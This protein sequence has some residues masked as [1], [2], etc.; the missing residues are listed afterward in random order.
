MENLQFRK[1]QD[2]QLEQRMLEIESYTQARAQQRQQNSQFRVD[3]AI[4]TI[5]VVVHVIYNNANQNISD[6]QIQSQIDVI[7]EDFRR[8]NGDADNTWSQAADTQIEFCMAT[9]DPNGNAT[10][11]ITRKSSTR[12][13]WGTNDAMKSTSQGGVNPWPT[14]EYL[15][16]W[17]CNI[18]GGILGYAQFPGG[19]ASTDG[20]VMSPQYFGS[21]DKGSGFFLS[22]PFDK[23]RTTTHEIGHFLNL[24]H[25][26]GD[27]GCGVDDFV[28]DT[29]ESDASNGGCAT[30][31][32]SCGS[33]DMVQNYMD[34]SDDS[35]M[36]LFT[37]GQKNRMRDVLEAGGS[38]RSLALSDKCGAVA[39]P[40]CTD[41]VQNGDE[42]G[43]DCGGS[44]C[45]P[46]STGPQ[47]CD[48][49]GNNT[50]DEYISRVQIE[51][52]NNVS[53]V[54]TTSTGYSDFTNIST[55]LSKGDSATITITPTWPGTLY[56]EGYAVFID[57]NQDGDFTDAGETVFTNAASQTTPVVGTFTV[58]NGATTGE[59]RMRV[60]MKYNG[61][62][63]SCES[64][65]YGEVEDYIVNITVATADTQA[66][67]T[68]I[69]LTASET[70]QTTTNLSWNASTDNV[71]VTSY[72]VF[73]G[74]TSLGTTANTSANIT[75][76][77]A[78]TSYSY[79]VRATDAAGNNSGLSNTASITTL[80]E[81][82]SGC[83]GA[84]SSFPYNEGFEGGLGAWSQSTADD[85]NWTVDAS[86][87]PSGSTGPSSAT[88]GSNY[89]YV[90]ASVQ[91]TGYPDARAIL[92]SPCFDLSGVPNG[93]FN[94]S[95]HMYGATD[96]GRID[97]EVSSN[98]GTSWTSV[99]N[100]TGNKGNSWLTASVDLSAYSGSSIQLRFN[101]ITGSTWQADIAIDAVSLTDGSAPADKCAGVL[102]WSSTTSYSV[103]DQVTYQGNLYERTATGWI[104]LGACGTARLANGEFVEYLGY[105]ITVYPNP[106]KGNTLFVKSSIE[107]L[108]FTVVNM[109]GQQVA[110]GTS[111]NGVNVSGLDAGLYMIQFNVNN[112]LETRKFIKQ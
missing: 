20:V 30:T 86:G 15:N 46:C 16:M 57:Y 99:W 106:V 19:A 89:V 48:S 10:N 45:S 29:P 76:L 51:T 31:H 60:S 83:T 5:P 7:N 88:E 71:G 40:T 100:Q 44:S 105:N 13:S 28:S 34:Y 103:E 43:V 87:T 70:T 32:V 9:V 63:T 1:Q 109:L 47:Y 39:Q 108:E 8:L 94:F 38:R 49:N 85:I 4:I 79:R 41:G 72:E 2:P 18:G 35:C 77:T 73:Q 107:S 6:A 96:M 27:G 93:T 53:G 36:N 84:I 82:S 95:Y 14:G 74:N 97:L 52:I 17:V 91:G 11:G 56:N 104:N 24:R 110:K 81:V 69:N 98:N 78:N 101:R 62:P 50:N 80:P 26:W 3:G 65:Q 23:G 68:P 12:T 25:I 112:K 111:R 55:D 90:E 66:P 37:Q 42:T 21:S 64:F 102:P 92:N 59:T 58:P 33:L 61:I 67:S 54:G 75:G 22:A